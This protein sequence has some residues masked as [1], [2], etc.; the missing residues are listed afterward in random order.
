MI[1]SVFFYGSYFTTHGK[2]ILFLPA[3]GCGRRQALYSATQS[4]KAEKLAEARNK[5][6]N[7]GVGG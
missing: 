1:S 2:R 4:L 3:K 7:V 5:A 6:L